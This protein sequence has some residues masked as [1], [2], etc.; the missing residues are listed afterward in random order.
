MRRNWLIIILTVLTLLTHFVFFGH[1][2]QTVFDEVHFGKFISGYFTGEYFFDIHPPLGKLL[3]S[4]MGYIAGFEP[5]FSFSDIGQEFNDK[6]YLWLRFLPTL[7]GALLPIVIYYLMLQLKFSRMAAFAGGALIAIENSILVQSRFI[8]LDSFLLL[9]GFS[10]LL[11][12]FK[13]RK[14]KRLGYLAASGILTALAIS[15]KWTGATFLGL[16]ILMETWDILKKLKPGSLPSYSWMHLRSY[17]IIYLS[18]YVL[19]R[20][21]VLIVLPVIIY[22]SFFVIHLKLLDRSGSGDAFMSREFQKTLA[23]SVHENDGNV[24]SLNIFEKFKELNVEMYQSNA[25]LS[26]SHP[27]SSAWYTWPFMTRPIYYWNSSQELDTNGRTL[28]QSRIYLIGNPII[29]WA[30][31]LAML[32]LLIELARS[33]FKYTTKRFFEYPKVLLF[34][35]IGFIF[36]LLPFVGIDRVMFLYHY[37]IALIFSIMGLAYLIDKSE[38]R[39][40][41]LLFI[42]IAGLISFLFF[43]PLTYGLPLSEGGYDARVWFATWR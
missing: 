23:G 36:N 12:Y 27:Y 25:R 28:E 30:S 16:I 3:I 10:A 22:F 13:Y 33:V 38:N 40:K 20:L 42:L 34:L 18:P 35:T 4:G 26:A 41:I 21:A 7:A 19:K 8:L 15:V 5:G 29:W 24:E 6:S 43:A 32:Y 2:D 39:K 9:F 17:L 1:P 11:L 14:S 37:T 31:T